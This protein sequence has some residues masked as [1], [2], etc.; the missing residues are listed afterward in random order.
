MEKKNLA[1]Y[2]NCHLRRVVVGGR[3]Q[4]F[5]TTDVQRHYEPYT[6]FRLQFKKKKRRPLPFDGKTK[7]E[8][9][10]KWESEHESEPY[11]MCGGAL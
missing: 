5:W 3:Y 9:D 10:W 2:D 8:N 11:V 7:V 6:I 1:R 4:Q